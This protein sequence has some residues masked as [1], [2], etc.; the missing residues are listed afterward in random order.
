MALDPQRPIVVLTGAGISAESGIPT[1]RDAN[2]LWENHAIEEVASPEGYHANPVL[3]HRFYSERRR[4]L[5]EV[6]PNAAHAALARLESAWPGGVL[7]V[8]QNVD[9]L[10]ERA[11]SRRVVHLHGELKKARCLLCRQVSPWEGDLGIMDPCPACGRRTLR[12][13]VVWFG[14]MVL[15]MEAVEEALAEATAFVAIGTSGQVYPAS[16]LVLMAQPWAHTLELNLEASLGS[17]LFQDQRFGRATEVVPAW[18]A[19]VLG[20]A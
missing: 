3:V 1:F 8:T 7:I 6:A 11:G 18:V 16:S 5:A 9:D 17:P 15:G 10:H 4:R 19:E 12:P 13:H 20:Q 14:E 2:G